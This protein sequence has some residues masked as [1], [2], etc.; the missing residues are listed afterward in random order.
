LD[1]L[2]AEEHVLGGIGFPR[3]FLE[4]FG[5]AA[6]SGAL[7]GRRGVCRAVYGKA[8]RREKRRDD[9]LRSADCKSATQ[10]IRNLRYTS[11]DR[12]PSRRNPSPNRVWPNPCVYS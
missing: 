7:E 1:A 9:D 12:A 4:P 2:A 6:R 10:Q 8:E 5:H 3:D 11:H